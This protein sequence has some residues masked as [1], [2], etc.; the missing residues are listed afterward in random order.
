LRTYCP[1]VQASLKQ[2]LPQEAAPASPASWAP[3]FTLS[4]NFLIKNRKLV[5]TTLRYSHGRCLIFL[6]MIANIVFYTFACNY[7]DREVKHGLWHNSFIYGWSCSNSMLF[8]ATLKNLS[9]YLYYISLHSF[10][11]SLLIFLKTETLFFF[12]VLGT[13]SYTWLKVC[14]DLSLNKW[15][16]TCVEDIRWIRRDTSSSFI[17]YLPSTCYGD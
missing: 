8:T 13:E 17:N 5:C 10:Y 3:S 6:L 4:S 2:H 15:N 1:F 12:V 7:T 14:K 11:F 9:F 16:I